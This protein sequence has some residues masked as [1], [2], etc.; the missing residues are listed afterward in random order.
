MNN[1]AG[2]LRLPLQ[3]A[4]IDRSPSAAALSGSGAEAS[5]SLSD[6]TGVLNTVGQVAGPV[7]GILGS[8]GI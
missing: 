5:F 7:M 3:A 8:L 1:T 6:I 4:P 2:S